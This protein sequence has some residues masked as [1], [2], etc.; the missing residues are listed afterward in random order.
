MVC[1]ISVLII[2]SKILFFIRP[3]YLKFLFFEQ[4]QNFDAFTV[5]DGAT[6]HALSCAFCGRVNIFTDATMMICSSI[7][8][9]VAYSK[10]SFNSH[11]LFQTSLL[12]SL[13]IILLLCLAPCTERSQTVKTEQLLRSS[14]G[15]NGISKN[16]ASKLCFAKE[17]PV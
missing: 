13:F 8:N 1:W 5:S 14:T 17:T 11:K 15:F 12:Q 16:K 3:P 7:L 2:G 9:C 10:E 4:L 6:N